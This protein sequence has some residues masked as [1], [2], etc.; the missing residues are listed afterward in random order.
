MPA[1]L[2]SI[3]FGAAFRAKKCG[4]RFTRYFSTV[5][6]VVQFRQ[7]PYCINATL[8]RMDKNTDCPN[9]ISAPISHGIDQFFPQFSEPENS[10]ASAQKTHVNTSNILAIILPSDSESFVCTDANK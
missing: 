10:D 6:Q 4:K 3:N 8:S 5:R 1:N 2:L 7:K 9:A